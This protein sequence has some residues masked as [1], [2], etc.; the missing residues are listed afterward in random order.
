VS[1]II[2]LIIDLIKAIAVVIVVAYLLTRTRLYRQVMDRQ[3]TWQGRL[4]LILLFGA[5]SVW[6]TL[7]G[8]EVLG[9]IAN[10][11]DLGPMLGGLLGGPL[12]GLGAGVIGA[13]QRLTMGG[14]TAV[15]CALATVLAGLA[16]GV[17][18]LIFR[19][20][21]APVWVAMLLAVVVESLHMGLVLAT[22]RPFEQALEIVGEVVIPMIL[23]NAVGMGVFVFIVHNEEKEHLIAAQKERM[24]GEL[25]VARDIQ[26]GIVP[27]IFPPFPERREID[28]HASL[29]S[30][31]EV[32]GDL[33]DF[34]FVDD[35]RLY[36]AIGDVS[37]KGVP[38]SL[39]MA[40]TLTLLR[41]ESRRSMAPEDV[42]ARVNAALCRNNETAMFVTLFFGFYD[43][44]SGDLRYSSGGHPPPFI[45]RAG[46]ARVEPL[47][48]TAGAGL[49]IAESITF[50]AASVT[51]APGD[52]LV[53]YSDGVTEA[54]DA[55]DEMFG[56][57]RLQTAL[58]AAAGV[59]AA[60]TTA[61]LRA[62]IERFGSGAEQYDDITLLALRRTP[63]G[64]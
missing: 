14:F 60:H 46:G 51:L 44:R 10:T 31:R 23:V 2:D 25:A 35:D 54:M 48:R 47:M 56:E 41:T 33:Y 7:A 61:S 37:G 5:F 13:L 18:F 38:A 36:L 53:A 3:F 42:L 26:L 62:A 16:G 8:V 17:V 4:F 63:D 40:I 21:V 6:G 15:P 28:L 64:G 9:G 22:A 39:F 52:E 20:R 55:A 27:A 57:Q 34:E 59:G 45:I 58:G 29:E 30:A 50:G 32:G 11:R 1:E 43:V 49:G 24:E 12:V 19:K